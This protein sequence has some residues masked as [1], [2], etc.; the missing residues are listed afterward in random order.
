MQTAKSTDLT[1]APTDD[2]ALLF[3]R[4]AATLSYTGL[5]EGAVRGARLGILDTL[6]VALAATGLAPNLGIFEDLVR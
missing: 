3:A 5:S 2:A 1:A 4:N 6:G